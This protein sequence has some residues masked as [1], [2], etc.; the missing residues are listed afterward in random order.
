[1]P[2][3]YALASSD[4]DA[5]SVVPGIESP[6]SCTIVN[7]PTEAVFTVSKTFSDGNPVAGVVVTPS[8]TNG[9]L[10]VSANPADTIASESTDVNLT[11]AYF[12]PGASCTATESPL[13]GY[14]QGVANDDCTISQPIAD[15]GG[16][17]SCEFLNIQNP[18]TVTI[19]KVYM[20]ADP[21]ND[22]EVEITLTCPGANITSTNPVM[23]SG[24]KAV[25]EVQGFPW[26]G[27]VC[28]ATETV[29]TGYELADG[30][31]CDNLAV[32]PDGANP[33][34][35]IYNQRIDVGIATLSHFGLLL[36]SLLMLGA[37]LVTTLQS[38]WNH[39]SHST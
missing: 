25:F 37:G 2:A 19:F 7:R 21:V 17:N 39:G 14:S 31:G 16:D 24:G 5:V 22:P 3:G 29:P 18:A 26:S 27:E 10:I 36:L 11:V 20:Y 30:T 1:V 28:E 32:A 34:C 9:G 15:I 13:A 38:R 23:T 8:C 12:T 4:C 35:T 6:H 33:D